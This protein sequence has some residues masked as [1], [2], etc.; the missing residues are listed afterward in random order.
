MGLSHSR[1]SRSYLSIGMLRLRVTIYETGGIT[2]QTMI[3]TG[4][5][6]ET[7]Q[8]FGWQIVAVHAIL[9]TVFHRFV[10]FKGH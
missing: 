6:S 7:R 8:S 5:D 10:E 1:E 3:C 9:F 2:L 4:K